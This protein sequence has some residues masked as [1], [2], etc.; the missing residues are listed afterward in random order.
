MAISDRKRTEKTKKQTKKSARDDKKK[1]RPAEKRKSSSRRDASRK[2]SKSRNAILRYFQDTGEEL[3]KVAWPT[4]EQA[5]RL[6]LI[7]L[8][9]TIATAA[10]F[11]VLDRVFQWLASFLV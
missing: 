9:S 5:V 1:E 8:G 10:F 11:G 2:S 6:T 4:R 3:R 7:V